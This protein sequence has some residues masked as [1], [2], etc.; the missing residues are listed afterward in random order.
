MEPRPLPNIFQDDEVVLD[1]VLDDS[2]SS[3]ALN[4]AEFTVDEQVHEILNVFGDV[5]T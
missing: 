5:I 1:F 4:A 3:D 2:L